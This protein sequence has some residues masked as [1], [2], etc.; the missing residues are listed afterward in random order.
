M[1]VVTTA[2]AQSNPTEGTN[3]E[4][5]ALE[6]GAPAS[7]VFPPFDSSTFAS[8]LL[9]LAITF[10]L[11][12]LLMSRVIVPRIGGIL[13][14]RRD[15]IA[16]DLDEANRLKEEADNA[17]AAY[18]Q[19]LADARKKASAIAETAREKAKAAAEAERA[20]TEA[21]LG[22]K[23]AEAEKSIAAIKTKAL[24]DVDTIAEDAATD[25]VK[26]LLG[27][28]VTKAEVAAAIRAAS[29]K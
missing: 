4:T 20:S 10:G 7:G 1:F 24:A 2:Y 13:E 25:V 15:R 17:I 19:E 11:F 29:G 28:S 18:E 9:W 14:H 16:Q 8:Q 22:A 21:E 3:S 23:M 26:H 5:G 12:Y 6:G 27:G